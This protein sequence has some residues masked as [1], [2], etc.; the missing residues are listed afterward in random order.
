MRVKR[1]KELIENIP[2]HYLVK[3][4]DETCIP[5]RCKLDYKWIH[6]M[7]TMGNDEVGLFIISTQPNTEEEYEGKRPDDNAEEATT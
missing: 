2:D 1:L 4:H 3:I 7:Y 5:G 6:D